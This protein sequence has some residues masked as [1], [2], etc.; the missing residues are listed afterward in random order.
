MDGFEGALR[1]HGRDGLYG[2]DI[3]AIQVNMGYL[4]NM[5]CR[6]CHLTASPGRTEVM[7]WSTMEAVLAAA[8]AVPG[9]LVD[10][11]G[12]APE[13]VPHFPRFVA[14]LRRPG[15]PV[16]VRTNLA[17]LLEPGME[18]MPEFYRDYGVRLVGSLP[19]YLE[20][21]VRAQRGK[22]AYEKSIEAIRRL[23]ALGYGRDPELPLSLVYNPGGPFLPPDQSALEADYR[24]EL[25]DRFGIAFSRLF[26]ITNMPIGRFLDD[27]CRRR[28][29]VSYWHLL[30]ESF[31]PDTLDGL[32][33][34]HQISI[35][36]DG[37]L[38]DCD[39][40]LALSYPID[41]GRENR[42]D[43][44]DLPALAVRRIVTGD[45]CFGCTAGPGS[46][47]AG[48]VAGFGG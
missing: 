42:I 44:V 3:S 20:E 29:D 25:R 46:S 9:C 33:C 22:G 28:K 32:M 14:A 30:R 11:T 18:S 12:G 43:R 39:F 24:R 34:R 6:H 38:Y 8:A 47:C 31:N 23:N 45:H 15:H 19:C 40:N 5:R 26:T 41:H 4:C 16:Q 10:V 7:D 21:N 2:A 35:G 1:A 48:A 37:T 36:W 27:L 13:W 17:V